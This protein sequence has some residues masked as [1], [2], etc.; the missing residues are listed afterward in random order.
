MLGHSGLDQTA[1]NVFIHRQRSL[2]IRIGVIF[3]ILEVVALIQV[4][5]LHQG[6]VKLG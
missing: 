4:Q 2:E 3:V 5:P 6:I 1:V